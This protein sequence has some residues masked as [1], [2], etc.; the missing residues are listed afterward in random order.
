MSLI[1]R[2][3]EHTLR[4]QPREKAAAGMLPYADLEARVRRHTLAFRAVGGEAFA[5]LQPTQP[6]PQS[7]G[8]HTPGVRLQALLT[9]K[10]SREALEEWGK[11]A[12][13]S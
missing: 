12:N 4:N 2:V 9:L 13:S 6:L 10:E 11:L 8:E 3:H 5:P 7:F 1:E